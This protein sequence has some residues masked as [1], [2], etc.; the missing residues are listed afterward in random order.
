METG[1]YRHG[2][3]SDT[4][5]LERNLSWSGLLTQ[6]DPRDFFDLRK[7]GRGRSQSIHACISNTWYPKE[8]RIY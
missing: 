4:E 7:H 1:A 2:R 3:P 8:V 6:P 5:W